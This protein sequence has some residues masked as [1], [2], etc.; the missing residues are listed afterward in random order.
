MCVILSG[1]FWQQAN[2]PLPAD[3]VTHTLA[4]EAQL[5]LLGEMQPLVRQD[6]ERGG[7]YLDG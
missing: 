1:L 3:L 2:S 6:S 4:H 7:R 5:A